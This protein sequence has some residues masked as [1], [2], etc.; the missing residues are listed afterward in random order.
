MLK[1]TWIALVL[2][3]V[4]AAVAQSSAPSAGS[5]GANIAIR[6]AMATPTTALHSPKVHPDRNAA[7]PRTQSNTG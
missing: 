7:I 4:T 2:T 5:C 1:T 6:G 3:F